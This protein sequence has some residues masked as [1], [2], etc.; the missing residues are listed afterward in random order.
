MLVNI[1]LEKTLVSQ[2][3]VDGMKMRCHSLVGHERSLGIR[4]AAKEPRKLVDEGS[5]PERC[6]HG[7]RHP[8]E[9][10]FFGC[11]LLGLAE[12]QTLIISTSGRCVVGRMSE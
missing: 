10:T 1:L 5:L 6:Q 8:V 11:V 2:S 3:M 9:K 4:K 12:E 7:S